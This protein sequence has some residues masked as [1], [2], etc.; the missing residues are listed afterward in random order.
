L[1]A[2]LEVV[3]AGGPWARGHFGALASRQARSF[4]LGVVELTTLLASVAWCPEIASGSNL[5]LALCVGAEGGALL[6]RPRPNSR[7]GPASSATPRAAVF[8]A[9]AGAWQ[10]VAPWS[11][12]LRAKGLVLLNRDE[13]LVDD[14]V[15]NPRVMFATQPLGAEAAVLVSY[16]F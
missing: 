4:E 11:V 1:G 7:L 2:N 6:A 12:V 16:E 15:G 14:L 9:A 8:A 13:F 3:V 5:G 10:F